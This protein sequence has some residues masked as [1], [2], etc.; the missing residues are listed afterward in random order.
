[1]LTVRP[2]DAILHLNEA[3]SK[4][5]GNRPISLIDIFWPE[6]LASG[7]L[8]DFRSVTGIV[9]RLVGL[10]DCAAGRCEDYMLPS[11]R[12]GTGKYGSPVLAAGWNA[13]EDLPVPLLKIAKDGIITAS[14]REARSLLVLTTTQ[15]SRVQDVLYGFVRPVADWVRESLTGGGGN[16]SQFLH[17]RGDN[18]KT[19]VQV[20]LNTADGSEGWH[21]IAVLNHVTELKT[22]EGQFVQSQ[23]MQAIGQLAWGH[24]P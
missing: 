24:R 19:F 9:T 14:N 5:P 7:Q 23:K 15:E 21:L 10:V 2:T 16:G 22:L 8:L 1:M 4:L 12:T 11:G 6:Q 13:I 3:F 18:Q 20:T 17:G